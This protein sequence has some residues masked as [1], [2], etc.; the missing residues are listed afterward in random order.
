M[1][2]R[3][4]SGVAAI[5]G[6]GA[7]EFSKN[8]GRSEWQ[9]ACE[10]VLAALEDAQIGVEEVDG[11]A[12]FTMETNPEIAVARALGIPELRFFS[13]IPHGGGGACAPV[14]QAALAVAGG[15]ADVV[16][17]YRAFNERS[18]HRFGSGP[19]PFA[20]TANTD[21][22]YRN[23]INPYGLLTPAQQ[24][25]FL[26]RRYMHK[27]GATSADFGQISVLS[28]KH[29]ATNPKAWFHGRPITLDDHQNSK[30]IADPLRLL[31]C[32]QESDG[33]QALVIVSAE[34]ARDLPHPP[35]IISAAA[36][37]VGPQQISMSSYYRDDIDEMPE[38]DLVARQ[39]WAQAGIGPDDI[40]AAVLYDAFT[41]MVLLQLEEYGF[42]GRGEAKDFIA[43]GNL[44]LDGRL[45]I[46]THGGQLG[47]GYIHGVNGIAEGVRLI[48]GSS[49]NQP[50]GNL[51]HVLVTGGSPV[52]HSAIVLS[53]DH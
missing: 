4:L 6:I 16:V 51:G 39:L 21:Q 11:F 19:P 18:G 31:D 37:G 42:C 49:V 12:L 25:A 9:L 5:A 10:S 41:P 36:Q 1:T 26:A 15:V 47:E 20:Y 50:A 40:D 43:D 8:S 14:Q 13:R 27:Y 7:T 44:E 28:R 48:R 38:V 34:R 45:P 2:G 30:L 33:G 29:A 23:W 32:C 22:E 17:V 24:E 35:A 53:A 52:P 46:N 3:E